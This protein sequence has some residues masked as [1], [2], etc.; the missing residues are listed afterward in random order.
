MS[1]EFSPSQAYIQQVYSAT[2]D[3]SL[4]SMPKQFS[5][6]QLHQSLQTL[7]Y[8]LAHLSQFLFCSPVVSS[9][10]GEEP[11]DSKKKYQSA[12]SLSCGAGSIN[13]LCRVADNHYLVGDINGVIIHVAY[14]NGS[15]QEVSAGVDHGNLTGISKIQLISDSL[16]IAF[17]DDNSATL[18]RFSTGTGGKLENLGE[19]QGLEQLGMVGFLEDGMLV[20]L[21][22][23]SVVIYRIDSGAREAV[24]Q[25]ESVTL[26]QHALGLFV[27][28]D[29]TFFT[30]HSPDMDDP[31]VATLSEKQ[32]VSFRRWFRGGQGWTYEEHLSPIRLPIFDV[33][34]RSQTAWALSHEGDVWLG[35]EQGALTCHK[36]SGE[37][38]NFG[39]VVTSPVARIRPLLGGKVFVAGEDGSMR[40]LDV[41]TNSSSPLFKTRNHEVRDVHVTDRGEIITAG[42]DGKVNLWQLR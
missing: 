11:I 37:V 1:L 4:A 7:D 41:H 34:D 3:K 19:I 18:H 28:P 10:L 33:A 13:T 25:H 31:D 2:L 6:S 16:C 17:R 38:K 21:K 39:V 30:L 32:P 27:L 24:R 8:E 23:S 14:V 35:Q 40:V 9:S 20:G 26:G 12:A 29:R 22:S 36:A 5:V 15:W 42:S